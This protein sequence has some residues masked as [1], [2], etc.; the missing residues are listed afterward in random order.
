MKVNTKIRY[1]LRAMLEFGL[2]ENKKNFTGL[3]QK[4][5][6]ERQNLSEKY[7]D[8]I[9]GA[10]KTS[11]LIINVRGKKSGY[12]LA[13]PKEEITVYDIYRSFEPELSIIHCVNKPVT[14]FISHICVASEYWLDLNETITKHMKSVTLDMIVKKHIIIKERIDKTNAVSHCA[15]AGKV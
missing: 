2:N 14:C 1:G 10:L 4:D 12:I 5:I 3:H 9:I 15:K 11:G 13:R 7:L 6:A 8:P